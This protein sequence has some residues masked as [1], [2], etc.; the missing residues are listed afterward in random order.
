MPVI[1]TVEDIHVFNKD[2]PTEQAEIL[3]RDGLALARRVAPCIDD[4]EFAF[5]DAAAAIIRG[6]ILRWA[7]SGSGG[8]TQRQM[9]A[10]P[11]AQNLSFDNRQSRRSL[12][13]PSEI[14]ELQ[15]LCKAANSDGAFGIDTI[16]DR[17]SR[18][19]RDYEG[20]PYLMGSI[21]SPCEACG[22]TLRPGWWLGVR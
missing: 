4:E 3:I 21:N 13:F 16:V 5:A 6:A 14:T 11:F 17:P 15:D 10:G 7:E 22:E 1:I 8:I 20:C 18:C 9:S 12:F 2:I 19:V